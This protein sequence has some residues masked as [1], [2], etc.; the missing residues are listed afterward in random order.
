MR[1]PKRKE[2]DRTIA[3]TS[4]TL[5]RPPPPKPTPPKSHDFPPLPGHNAPHT[6]TQS[7]AKPPTNPTKTAPA[8]SEVQGADKVTDPVPTSSKALPTAQTTNKSNPV[9]KAPRRRE[10]HRY[11]QEAAQA[12]LNPAHET[13]S[14]APVS[15]TQHHSP[16]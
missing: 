6:K 1:F 2:V 11:R 9:P 15:T 8:R 14:P 7:N 16:T 4:V 3:V 13:T 12:A 5:P 10:L